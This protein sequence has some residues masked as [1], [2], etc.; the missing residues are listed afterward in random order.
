MCLFIPLYILV[1]YT[2]NKGECHYT[3]EVINIVTCITYAIHEQL[4][5]DSI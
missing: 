5:S 4:Q 2:D 3:I 1:S